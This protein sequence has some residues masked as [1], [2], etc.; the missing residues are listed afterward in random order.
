MTTELSIQ[1]LPTG[2]SLG[3]L[4]EA[5][6]ERTPD[7]P[8]VVLNDSNLSFQQLN[9]L[10]NQI[11]HR[12]QSAGIGPEKLVGVYLPRSVE[13]VAAVLGILKAGGAYVPLDT[14]DPASRTLSILKDAAISVVVT[15]SELAGNL[16]GDAF[17]L[18][19]D[20]AGLSQESADNLTTSATPENLAYV[21]F[22]SGTTG[23]PKGVMIEQRSVVHLIDS[24][25]EAI[26]A[27]Y[28]SGLRVSLTANLSFDA[29]V[30]QLFQ[31]LNG[32][33]LVVIPEDA[34]RDGGKLLSYITSKQTDIVDCTPSLLEILLITGLRNARFTNKPVFLIGGEPIPQTLWTEL[35]D[36]DSCDFYN[37]YGP[38]ECTV[39]ATW[40]DIRTAPDQPT[41]GLPLPGV[42]V[43]VVD[44][45]LRPVPDGIVG[46]LAIGG[47]GVARGYLNSPR[48]TA[49]KFIPDDAGDR[50]YRTGDRAR[51]TAGGY[52]QFI[53]RND[54]QVKIRGYRVELGEIESALS[55]HPEIRSATVTVLEDGRIAGYVV[56]SSGTDFDEMDLRRHCETLL[57]EYMLPSVFLTLAELP[58]TENGK[59]DKRLLPA[60]SD[61]PPTASPSNT[62]DVLEQV[63]ITYW[64]EA[65]RVPVV[66]VDDDFFEMGGN[67]IAATQMISN[68]QSFFPTD[69]PLLS[70][71]FEDPT[72]AGLAR[73]IRECKEEDTDPDEVAR[74]LLRASEMTDDEMEA[75]LSE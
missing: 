21:L 38:T 65:L 75:M 63:L 68:L 1:C 72:V 35:K 58:L 27:K 43:R 37:L 24:L 54:S 74:L 31:L 25:N 71:F 56:L 49:E 22:S 3:R 2:A 23:Q 70:L 40:A 11:A 67:S 12:L 59:V 66:G 69:D 14:A 44:S 19:L 28:Q 53:G 47:N 45:A 18:N 61:P 57:P 20:T 34:R 26:Y 73:G 60:P 52:F 33:T 4:F 32:H 9:A 13:S 15:L 29:S 10:S 42:D 6:V 48:L 17:C 39:D 51:K 46:E 41:I 8:A 16:S 50:I 62:D 64:A 36:L 30:K 7:R 5:Q 55:S